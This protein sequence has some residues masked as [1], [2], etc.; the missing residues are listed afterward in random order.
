MCHSGYWAIE[1][2][3]RERE[4]RDREAREKRT[5]TINSLLESAR[6]QPPEPETAPA[7]EPVP[8]K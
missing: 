1:Q 4:A 5:E 3:R 2:A 8:A 6:K 7:K